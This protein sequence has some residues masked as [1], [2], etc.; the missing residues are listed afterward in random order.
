M[1]NFVKCPSC[2]ALTIEANF[3]QGCGSALENAKIVEMHEDTKKFIGEGHY[4][5]DPKSSW[6]N[7]L[8]VK[9]NPNCQ[10]KQCMENK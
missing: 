10:C 9:Q 2:E 3:C 8:R 6:I 4:V 1:K 7:K 5:S